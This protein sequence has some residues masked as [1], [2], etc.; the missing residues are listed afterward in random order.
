MLFIQIH[1]EVIRYLTT[2]RDDDTMWLFH[3][4]D[5][6]HSFKGQLIEIQTVTHIIIGRDGLWV[7]VDHHRAPSLLA[8]RVQCLYTTP[9]EL[10]RRADAISPRTQY[11][12]A[13]LVILIL[14]I[15]SHTRISN[16]QIIGLRRILSC[17][18]VNLFHN[19]QDTKLFPAV[20]NQQKGFVHIADLALQ[21]YGTGYL[22]ICKAI[23]LSLTQQI[24]FQCVD[25]LFLQAL[26]DIY[27]MLQFL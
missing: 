2:S 23:D 22:E 27:D 6:Q 24:G 10:H 17:Q 16:I 5:I 11:D 14:D 13:L 15:M 9:V 18:R 3:V 12:D 25:V 4:D 1:S 7:I 8:D 21:P 19:R 26:V 20:T